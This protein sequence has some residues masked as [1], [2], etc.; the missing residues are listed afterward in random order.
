M[1]SF[2]LI[3][4]LCCCLS[5]ACAR[6]DD[7]HSDRRAQVATIIPVRVDF[8]GDRID[9]L[10]YKVDVSWPKALPNKWM[11]ANATGLA[12]DKDDHL[13]VLNRP[14]QLA[15]DDAGS[16]VP[17]PQGP[18]GDCCFPAPSLVQF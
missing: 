12:I 3:I 10:T 1:K 2:A 13:W 17:P 5:A 16:A 15:L 7:A 6:T 8:P 9:E 4:G 11:L 14:R 18:Y